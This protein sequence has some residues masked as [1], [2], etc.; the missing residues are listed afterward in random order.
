MC[1]FYR[2]P[3]CKN[4]SRLS[5]C[6]VNDYAGMVHGVNDYADTQYSNSFQIKFSFIDSFLLF[7]K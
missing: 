7:F 4:G 1:E 2:N 6:V 3:L 5:V